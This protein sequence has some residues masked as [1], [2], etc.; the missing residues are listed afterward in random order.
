MLY[1]TT[2]KTDVLIIGGREDAMAEVELQQ[3]GPYLITELLHT[4]STGNYYRA[5]LRKKNILIKK[6]T[7][8]LSTPEEQ[9]AFLNR[10]K[11]LKKLKNRNIV[12]VIDA[13]FDGDSGYIAMEYVAGE[14]MRQRF[15]AGELIAPDEIRRYLSPLA[16]ALHYA[17]VNHTLHGNLPGQSVAG[18]IQRYFADRVC[19]QAAGKR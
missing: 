9:E 19:A 13:S 12:N 14:T 11:Q 16:E 2:D 7:I 15:A 6:L 18:A 17:H 10:A 5:K 8:S 1:C 4:S 3:I